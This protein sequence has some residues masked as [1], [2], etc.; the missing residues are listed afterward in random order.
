MNK[1]ELKKNVGHHV[2]LRPMAKRFAGGPTGPQLPPVND[3][4]LIQGF[5]RNGVRISNNATGHG[6]VLG[7]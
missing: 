6:T 3:D 7:V 1:S 5:E 2:R 4:W